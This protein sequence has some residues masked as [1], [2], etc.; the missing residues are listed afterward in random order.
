[1]KVLLHVQH[2]LGIGHDRRAA[3]VARGLAAAGHAVTVLRGGHPVPGSDYGAVDVVQLPPARSAD[4]S[5][6]IILDQHGDP[7][8]DT[9]RADRR[10]RVL[11][12]FD[13]VAPDA[14]LVESY[15]FARR[16][17]RFELLPLLEAARAAGAVTASS[18]RDILVAR[19]PERIDEAAAVAERL[20]DLVLVHGDPDLVPFEA[21]FP[22]AAR[23]GG[24]LRYTGY[25]TPPPSD[26]PPAREPGDDGRDE[27]VVSVGGGA[28]GRPLLA[29]ALAA[30]PLTPARD[31]VWRLLAGPD[32]PEAEMAALA[33][34]APPGV[35]V[36]RARP[37]F[38]ALLR[39]CRL[40]VSQAGYNTLL[41]VLQAGCPAV[42]V[43]FEAGAGKE[44]E[45]PTRA[46]LLEQRGR[47]VV[48]AEADLS[49][50]RLAAGIA[51]A[52][53]AP[54]APVMSLAIDGAARTA[55]LLAEA[56]AERRK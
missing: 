56:V 44:T 50:E 31:L 22:A 15:P 26:E 41:D 38:P 52:L 1:M 53:A 7:I 55:M 13:R 20:I 29:A 5:F 40:S 30:R 54:P 35:V 10:D 45:Q 21:S 28:V 47:L 32:L 42:V 49:A 6:R 8:D 25:V 39:R 3:L 17:F 11:A 34:A 12:V 16:A 48:V 14:V 37:D 24:R 51:R 43:P 36:E 4:E 23:L 2:L 18:V 19:K 9:W 27:V 33:A 46:R